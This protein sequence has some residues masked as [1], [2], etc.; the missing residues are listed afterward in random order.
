MQLTN[1]PLFKTFND[2]YCRILCDKKYILNTD[3]TMGNAKTQVQRRALMGLL[4][5]V[6]MVKPNYK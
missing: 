6:Q 5:S 4:Q 2:Y 3:L 1:K